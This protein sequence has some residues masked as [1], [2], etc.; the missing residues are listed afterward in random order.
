MPMFKPTFAAATLGTLLAA[1]SCTLITDVDRTKIPT[2]SSGGT[3]GSGGTDGGGKAGSGSGGDTG[4]GTSGRSAGQAG[5][6]GSGGTA[7]NP[8]SCSKATGT[9]TLDTATFLA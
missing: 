1:A 7:G 3:S 6:T 5:D 8:V 9:I 4:D 2:D